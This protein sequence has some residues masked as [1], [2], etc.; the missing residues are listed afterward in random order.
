MR[1]LG[2]EIGCRGS[3][4]QLL[5]VSAG[6]EDQLDSTLRFLLSPRSAYVSGQVVR[7]GRGVAPTPEIDWE[8]PLAGQPALVTGASR[9][10]GAAIAATLARDGARVVGLDV[11]QADDLRA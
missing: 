3:T 8:R 5:Y 6:A 10:I 1:S 4:A 11:P 2:K 7:I 9:G